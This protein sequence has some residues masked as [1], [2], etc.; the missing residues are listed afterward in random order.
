MLQVIEHSKFG[1]YILKEICTPPFIKMN[2]DEPRCMI[3]SLWNNF[4]IGPK[5]G[6]R[7]IER[8]WH[9]VHQGSNFVAS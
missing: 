4:P 9:C 3:S 5:T 1:F 8:M 7:I 2:F 6:A